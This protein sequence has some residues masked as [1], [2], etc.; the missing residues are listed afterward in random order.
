MSFILKYRVLII[1]FFFALLGF[2]ISLLLKLGELKW[3]HIAGT[4][5]LALVIALV[6]NFLTDTAWNKKLREKASFVSLGLGLLFLVSLFFHQRVYN[7]GTFRYEDINGTRRTY[8]KGYQYTE[9]AEKF[10][11]DNPD[12]SSDAQLLYDGFGGI[13]GKDY[14]WTQGSIKNVTFQLIISYASVILFL[15]ALL[16][17][18]F[19]VAYEK[20][21]SDPKTALQELLNEKDQSNYEKYMLSYTLKKNDEKY[22]Q[23]KLHVF[24]SYASNQ[25]AIAEEVYYSLTNNGH[26]VFFDR[27]NLPVG[28]EYNNAI[29]A[30][31][32]HSDAFIFMISPEAVGEGHY[33]I[34]ELKFAGEK[35]PAAGGVLLPVMAVTTDYNKI[36]AY[37][38]SVTVL[39][40]Q[41]NLVAEVTAEVE[42]M[43]GHHNHN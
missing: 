31:I 39:T 6:S 14:V 42:K 24:L 21:F 19:G 37:A 16:S 3:Y 35:W 34:T 30:A 1:T 12:I 17:W 11:A 5:L 41:G 40:A 9:I 7:N 43:F 27:A 36:P 4:P 13:E 18:V 26:M 38:K 25:R 2:L 8:I 32:G 33:T 28:L 15:S 10:K 23:I 29:H 20:R 22:K